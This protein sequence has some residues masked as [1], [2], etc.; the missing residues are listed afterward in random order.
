[1]LEKIKKYL[2][3]W[4]KKPSYHLKSSTYGGFRLDIDQ[5]YAEPEN[6]EKLK[7]INNSNFPDMV[8][9]HNAESE[10]QQEKE[11]ESKLQT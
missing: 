9:K 6:Q 8:K 2:K 3:F 7:Q 5:Y 11:A 10:M 1:M 4:N